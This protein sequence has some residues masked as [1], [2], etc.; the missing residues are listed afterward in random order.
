[1]ASP[2]PNTILLKHMGIT[3]IQSEGT[4]GGTIT[5]GM[6]VGM[7]SAGAIVAHGTAGGTAPSKSFALEDDLQGRGI[8]DNYDSTTYKQVRYHDCAPGTEVYAILADAQAMAIGDLLESA[9]NGTLR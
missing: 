2:T 5:P 9:G 8:N 7:N 6:L 3:S 4:A 1:M